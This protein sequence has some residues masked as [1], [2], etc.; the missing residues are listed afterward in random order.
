MFDYQGK[1]ISISAQCT[2]FQDQSTMVTVAIFL[3][4]AT[5][6]T[7]QWSKKKNKLI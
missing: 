1:Q 5:S 6:L 4:P 3:P 7:I 2:A